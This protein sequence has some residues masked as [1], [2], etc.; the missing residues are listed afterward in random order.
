MKR[1][2]GSFAERCAWVAE[3]LPRAPDA[4]S[5]AEL[6]RVLRLSDSYLYNLLGALERQG[7][8]ERTGP[9][10]CG[11]IGWRAASPA[12]TSSSPCVGPR[13]T[14]PPQPHGDMS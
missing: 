8:A 7:R 6:S 5:V 11:R 14:T 3:R 12:S 2:L 9:L 13:D 4:C 1:Y 10:P